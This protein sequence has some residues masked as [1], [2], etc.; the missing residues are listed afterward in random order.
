MEEII[1]DLEKN[2]QYLIIADRIN[3]NSFKIKICN[4][5]IFNIIL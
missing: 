3:G 5:D 4:K 1:F 2:E